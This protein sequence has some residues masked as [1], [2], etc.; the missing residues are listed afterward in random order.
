VP[1]RMACTR[2]ARGTR[3]AGKCA[4]GQLIQLPAYYIAHLIFWQRQLAWN[5]W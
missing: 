4:P 3:S 1:S 2:S 5:W